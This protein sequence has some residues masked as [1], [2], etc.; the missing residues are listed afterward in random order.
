M[1]MPVLNTDFTLLKS[2]FW[3]SLIC[4]QVGNM[5]CHVCGI[6]TVQEFCDSLLDKTD[7]LRCVS[8]NLYQVYFLGAFRSKLE[9]TS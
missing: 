9:Y 8:Y 2:T 7:V 1:G 4:I 3:I 6:N 5:G